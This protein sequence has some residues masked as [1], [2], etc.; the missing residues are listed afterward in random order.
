MHE[1]LEK[2]KLFPVF[3]NI[4]EKRIRKENQDGK[5]KEKDPEEEPDQLNWTQEEWDKKLQKRQERLDKEEQERSERIRKAS[6][7]EKGWELLNLCKEMMKEEGYHRQKSK[8][9]R[10]VERR[11]QERLAEA[12][13]KKE[14]TMEKLETRKLQTKITETLKE[15][16][17]NRRILLEREL[18]KERRMTLKEAKE[19][20]WKERE[21]ITRK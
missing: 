11:K 12:S 20:I 6:R 15:F 19:E 3:S 13:A 2:E 1:Y 8:E 9:R 18:E 10:E 7:L 16:P 4:T 17:R 5:N 14:C 21:K